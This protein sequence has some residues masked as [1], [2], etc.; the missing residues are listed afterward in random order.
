MYDLPTVI[1]THQHN[2]QLSRFDYRWIKPNT[3]LAH[4][5]LPDDAL[6]LMRS[7]GADACVLVEAGTNN[8]K[9]TSWFLE[10]AHQYSHVVG[11]VGYVDLLSDVQAV[12]DSLNPEHR[13]LLSGIRKGCHDPNEDWGAL[14]PGLNT[15]AANN[16]TCDLLVGPG[17]LPK[18]QEIISQ[19]PG[20]TFILD[21]FAG[22][23]L[24]PIGQRD[25]RTALAP[26]AALP[27]VVMKVSGYLTSAEPQPLNAE[28]LWSYLEIA[29]ELFGAER[30]MYGSDWPVCLL[31]GTYAETINL[32]HT[33]TGSL[34][35]QEQ[36]AL[37]SRTA[38]RTYNL[39]A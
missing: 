14:A 32:L 3:I 35:P 28:M 17:M 22:I 31:G 33:V 26:V 23:R 7:A 38:I 36:A 2:W 1:D 27:N 10:L 19:H 30:L 21:H 20:I 12:L 37:W 24:T 18:V 13:P 9:E 39:A 8:V 6:P 16:L 15:L 5:Y 34:S 4:D 29:L 11:V 25:W